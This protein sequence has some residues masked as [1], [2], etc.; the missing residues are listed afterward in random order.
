MASKEK[1]VAPP[2]LAQTSKPS[3]DDPWKNKTA[4][5]RGRLQYRALPDDPWQSLESSYE[6]ENIPETHP[7][8]PNVQEIILSRENIVVQQYGFK[9]ERAAAK[10]LEVPLVGWELEFPVAAMKVIVCAERTFPSWVERAP[11]GAERT[12]NS[13]RFQLVE[14]PKGKDK[15]RFLGSA[16]DAGTTMD[17]DSKVGLFPLA[18]LG[19]ELQ[20]GMEIRL[21][22]E[23]TSGVNP[24]NCY[25][26]IWPMIVNFLDGSG[27]DTRDDD[28]N[29][30]ALNSWAEAKPHR[31]KKITSIEGVEWRL[32]PRSPPKEQPLLDNTPERR[33]PA[34]WLRDI[35][36]ERP[37]KRQCKTIEEK[38]AESDR[39]L[40]GFK[41]IHGQRVAAE[42][43][44]RALQSKLSKLKNTEQN[45]SDAF[46][47]SVKDQDTT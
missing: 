23:G 16:E 1:T 32:R 9:F 12:V 29:K 41:R 26:W 24:K 10:A 40:R 39:L 15:S 17:A 43:E 5:R 36:L 34:D 44:V 20:P 37:E 3:L 19:R 14:R 46:L 30:A 27:Y 11:N 6:V 18:K 22:F 2:K 45:W 42:T 47:E 38:R 13:I 28:R 31:L 33:R 21:A 7:E 25:S 4:Q 8:P 35:E